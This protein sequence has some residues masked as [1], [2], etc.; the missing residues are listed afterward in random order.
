MLRY[1]ADR[2]ALLYMA[3]ITLLLPLQWIQAEFNV[4]LFC[5]AC[6]MAVPVSVMAHNHNHLGIW[7]NKTLNRLTDY[8]LTV[9]YGFPAFGWIPTHN[10]NHHKENNREGDY[11]ITYRF[12]EAN[13][14]LTLITYPTISGI[15]Q[16]KPIRE[17]LM[18]QW[19]TNRGRFWF[20]A[21]QYAVLV[22]ALGVAFALDWKKA[23]LYLVVPQQIALYS[24]LIFN[25]VQ[26]VHCDEESKINHS[27]NFVGW[28]LNAYLFNNG[29]HTIH[30]EQPGLH[31]SKAPEM[32]A[33]LVAP[34]IDPVLLERGFW[35]F[36]FRAYV[37]G[38]FVPR[39]R[40]QSM[41]LRRMAQTERGPL[42]AA[43]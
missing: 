12:T 28:F 13:N 10:M 39:Y 25:Y 27:R 32:H 1:S 36:I 4:L 42:A 22:L 40:T 34:H 6:F 18:K 31:W 2:K 37:V 26:H 23:L 24:V 29:F 33:K 3:V 21:S 43:A 5:L 30:H 9:F 16:Q 8:W 41:R 14:L 17:Y 15:Y 38:L 20:Y 11:T 35:P 19:H 7:K